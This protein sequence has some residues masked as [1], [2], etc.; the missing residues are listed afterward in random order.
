MPD[1]EAA[2][3]KEVSVANGGD[4]DRCQP[5]NG[6]RLSAVVA[7][8]PATDQTTWASDPAETQ[9]SCVVLHL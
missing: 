3:L 4:H 5:V 2:R 9:A 8:T 6:N 7:Q 1:R